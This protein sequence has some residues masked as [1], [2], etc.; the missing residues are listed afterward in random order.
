MSSG[1]DGAPPLKGRGALVTGRGADVW[2]FLSWVYSECQEVQHSL[3][4]VSATEIVAQETLC[5]CVCV[6]VYVC[7][8]LCVC[9]RL[10]VRVGVCVYV[11][12][13]GV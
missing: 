9:V 1:Q 8:C 12:L 7:V 4:V 5:V 11:R 10:R 2:R 13:K 6:C 3:N